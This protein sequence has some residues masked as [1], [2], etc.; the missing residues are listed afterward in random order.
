MSVRGS[1]IERLAERYALGV[2]RSI[3]GVL[4]LS[5]TFLAGCARRIPGEKF[6]AG[7]ILTEKQSSVTHDFVV[8][9]TMSQRVKI[10]DVEKTCGCASFSLGKYELASGE[11]TS[12]TIKVEAPNG[13]MRKY[14]ACV[15]KTDHPK[16]RDWSYTVQF[17]SLPFVVAEPE[18]LNLGCLKA[19]DGDANVTEHATLDLFADRRVELTRA[20]FV[21]PDEIDM[22]ISSKPEVRR[23]QRG[24]WNTRYSINVGLKLRGPGAPSHDSPSGVVTKAIRLEAKAPDSRRW[25]YSVYWQ[26]LPPL[27]VHPSYLVFGNVLSETGHDHVS[28]LLSSTTGEGFRVLSVSDRS[29]NITIES[30]IDSSSEARQH[31]IVFKKPRPYEPGGVASTQSKRFLSGTIQ[32]RTTSQLRPLVEIPWSAMVE[33]A[34][35]DFSARAGTTTPQRSGT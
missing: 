32:V 27:D 24:I 22:S 2:F 31:R 30:A 16:F 23:L 25:D 20:S 12:L 1:R 8:A 11:S 7:Y 28:V 18:V 3:L 6:D 4:L 33:S 26:E 15:L 19:G 29:H 14:A 9:N 10:L 21:A 13:Y 34:D 17:T 5:S 35:D